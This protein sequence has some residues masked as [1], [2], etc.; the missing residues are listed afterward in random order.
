VFNSK[1]KDSKYNDTESPL[2]S[3]ERY[4][5]HAFL[6]E[7]VFVVRGAAYEHLEPARG[8]CPRTQRRAEGPRVHRMPLGH[9]S[10]GFIERA[11]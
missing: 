4:S 1:L 10:L 8:L 9:I 5:E 7:I 2:T 3:R 11:Q 6:V